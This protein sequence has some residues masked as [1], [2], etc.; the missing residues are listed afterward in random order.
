MPIPGIDQLASKILEKPIE[1][2]IESVGPILLD[3]L[4]DIGPE[5]LQEYGGAIAELIADNGQDLLDALAPELIDKVGDLAEKAREPLVDI[6][7]GGA[8]EIAGDAAQ[9]V[10]DGLVEA[11]LAGVGGEVRNALG[12]GADHLADLSDVQLGAVTLAYLQAQTKPGGLMT[13]IKKRIG[14]T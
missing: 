14:R 4:G 10:V 5:L 1:Y 9:R 12:K 3:K 7:S 13:K 2:V 11:D 6:A 8:A